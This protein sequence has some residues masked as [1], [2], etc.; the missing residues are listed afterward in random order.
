MSCTC[1]LPLFSLIIFSLSSFNFSPFYM[2]FTIKV[3]LNIIFLYPV[4]LSM[5][6]CFD[7]LD[8]L[9]SPDIGRNRQY[10][11]GTQRCARHHCG[12]YICGH[13]KHEQNYIHSE[14][15]L[16]PAPYY[17]SVYCAKTFPIWSSHSRIW[18]VYCHFVSC[19]V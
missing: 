2:T 19:T 18:T 15:Q 11:V 1:V 5:S 13:A 4:S 6:G 12:E 8:M 9:M 3:F 17:G 7:T 10:P 14:D 16:F